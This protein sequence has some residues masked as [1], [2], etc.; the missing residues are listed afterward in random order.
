[1]KNFKNNTISIGRYIYIYIY[2]I[3]LKSIPSCKD[4]IEYLL[5]IKIYIVKYI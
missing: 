5:Q 1:M 3:Q 2:N 4:C